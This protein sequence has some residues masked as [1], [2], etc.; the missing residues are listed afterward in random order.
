MWGAAGSGLAGPGLRLGLPRSPA[1]A[2]SAQPCHGGA[3]AQPPPP[4]P[5]RGT[6]TARPETGTRGLG[7]LPPYL[8]MLGPDTTSNF[9]FI[10]LLFPAGSRLEHPPVFFFP[11]NFINKNPAWRRGLSEGEVRKQADKRVPGGGQFG[12]RVRTG[13]PGHHLH[14]L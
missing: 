1:Y 2:A 13:A 3:A 9:S 12:A 8:N 6:A 7:L 14:N 11:K 4:G 5:R 10:P